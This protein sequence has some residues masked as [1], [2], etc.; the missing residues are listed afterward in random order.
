MQK[1]WKRER[2]RTEQGR[3]QHGGHNK[4]LRPEQNQALIRY[5][6]NH[7]LNGGK[8]ATKQMMYNCAMYFRV[9]EG[10]EAPSWK[11]FQKWLKNTPELHIIKTK[12]IASHRVDMHTEQTLRDWFETHYRPAL[13]ATGIKH[14][15]NIHNMDEKGARVCMPAGEEVVVPIGI[16]EMYTGIPENRLSVIVIE[17]ILVDGK[18]IPPVII[19][20]GVMIMASWFHDNITG[21]ELITVSE[22][23]YTNEG[24]YMAWLDHFIKHNNCRPDKEWHILLIDG[25][26][27]HEAEDFVIK[28]KMNKI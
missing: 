26:T 6:V 7:A 19:V 12:P 28:A 20:P 11:W 8:G 2:R 15:R 23:G 18:A 1:A 22:S 13:V 5:A 3:R 17:C 27:C 21:H 10:K 4:I 25:A 9:Q 14:G 16:K 24:I